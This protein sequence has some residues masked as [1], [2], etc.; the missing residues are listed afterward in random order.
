MHTA[1]GLAVQIQN[2]PNPRVEKEDH[3]YNVKHTK[4]LDLGLTPHCLSDQTIQTFI[5]KIIHSKH[6]ILTETIQP[7][8]RWHQS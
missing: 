2:I 3:Y 7:H 6:A 5:E 4:L 1:F 8:V